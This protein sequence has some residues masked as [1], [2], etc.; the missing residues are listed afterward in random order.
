MAPGP[1]EITFAFGT[2][3]T[4]DD[5]TSMVEALSSARR[6]PGTTVVCDASVLADVD[7]T[8]IDALSRLA[9]AVRRSGRG[10]VVRNRSAALRDLIELC[11]LSVVLPDQLRRDP[12]RGR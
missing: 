1:S 11:G 3:L 4:I 10:L 9:L 12:T 8:T 2:T 7:C 6:A 5:V